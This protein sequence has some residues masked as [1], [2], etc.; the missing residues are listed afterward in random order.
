MNIRDSINE[1]VKKR[2]PIVSIP[3]RITAVNESKGVCDV[4]PLDGTAE[5]FDVLING[6][7][8]DEAGIVIVPAVDSVVFVTFVSKE[9]AFVSLSSV[10]DKVFIKINDISLV[11]DKDGAV[12]NDGTLDGLV[13]IN[14]LVSKL[15]AI[16][17]N[18][19]QLNGEYKSHIHTVTGAVPLVP[20]TLPV[21]STPLPIATPLL[22]PTLKIELE[23]LKVKQ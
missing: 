12:F 6:E 15:N 1:I 5:I 4:E 22:V 13:K 3:A 10:I 19:N 17:N 7:Q 21:A 11:L 23:N 2:M 16:E 9:V 18:V 8:T 14:D 20:P